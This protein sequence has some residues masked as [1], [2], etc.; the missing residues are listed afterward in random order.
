MI[1]DCVFDSIIPST[2]VFEYVFQKLRYSVSK[3]CHRGV[4]IQLRMMIKLGIHL[5]SWVRQQILLIHLI[6][7][8]FLWNP[9]GPR[10]RNSLIIE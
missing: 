9:I 6:I 10:A 4:Q 1:E 3:R 2:Q 8:I 5:G 7:E